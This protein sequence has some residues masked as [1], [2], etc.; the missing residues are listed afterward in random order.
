MTY[1]SIC[2]S[3]R[4]SLCPSI[5]PSVRPSVRPSVCVC[6]YIYTRNYINIDV[7][8]CIW[9]LHRPYIG[10]Y[11]YIYNPP[12]QRCW[13]LLH[14]FFPPGCSQEWPWA[15]LPPM[16]ALG[17]N[18]WAVEHWGNHWS[19]VSSNPL[20]YKPTPMGV[21]TIEMGIQ[22]NEIGIITNQNAVKISIYQI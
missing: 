21:E 8:V 9:L 7:C 18:P 14:Y 13:N 17:V 3:V 16:L 15:V 4:P 22:P 12:F 2:L 5:P 1:L 10:V 11:I 20:Y 6:I 19:L